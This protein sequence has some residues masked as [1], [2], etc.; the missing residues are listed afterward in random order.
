MIDNGAAVN[1]IKIG[2][3]RQDILLDTDQAIPLIDIN[4]QSVDTYDTTVINLRGR[5]IR[6]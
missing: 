3:L 4:D 1:V 2:A 5:P 6:L